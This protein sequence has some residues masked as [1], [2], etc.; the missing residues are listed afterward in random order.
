MSLSSNKLCLTYFYTAE[1]S[2]EI[3]GLF[4]CMSAIMLLFD[5]IVKCENQ[6]NLMHNRNNDT[7]SLM[8]IGET[9]KY[10]RK[11]DCLHL[12]ISV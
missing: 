11:R 12:N 1:K 2:G 4:L 5:R 7:G 8:P 6:D 10:I 3:S 9:C